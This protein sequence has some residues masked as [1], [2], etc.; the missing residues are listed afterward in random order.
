VDFLKVSFYG[1]V[2]FGTVTSWEWDFDGDGITDSTGQNPTHIFPVADTYSVKL[3]T[4]FDTG[5]T[6]SRTLNVIMKEPE[7]EANFIASVTS[8]DV[9]LEVEFTDLT[10][11]SH[12]C[13]WDFSDKTPKT[14]VKNPVH[15]FTEPGTYWVVL[16]ATGIN[17][18]TDDYSKEIIV[19]HPSPVALFT[20]EPESGKPPLSVQFTDRSEISEGQINECYW[21]FGDGASSEE[22]NP[23]HEYSEPG[24]YTVSLKVKSGFSRINTYTV[25]DL[26]S[27]TSGFSASFSAD[28][29]TGEAP[30][31]VKFTSTRPSDAE[32]KSYF[33]DFED[34]TSGGAHPVHTFRTPGIYNVTLTVTNSYGESYTVIKTGYITVEK[35]DAVSAADT[36]VTEEPGPDEASGNEMKISCQSHKEDKK[37]IFGIPGTEVFRSETTRIHEFY[38]EW[39]TLIRELLGFKKLF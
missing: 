23:V 5:S 15:V 34:G 7:L 36:Q 13:R 17:G 2:G 3:T 18:N 25:K 19:N 31:I 6:E 14:S 32:M 12:D 28:K 1:K 20:A 10:L 24:N 39:V 16:T 33:W 35:S 37:K 38:G 30:F 9:P 22:R 27:V 29:T 26:I 8:G 11:A 21:T 4:T